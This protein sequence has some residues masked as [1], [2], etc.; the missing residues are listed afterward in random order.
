MKK[1]LVWKLAVAFA[2]DVSLFA[3]RVPLCRNNK[4]P[5]KSIT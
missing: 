1:D 3:G 4:N 2:A 5:I